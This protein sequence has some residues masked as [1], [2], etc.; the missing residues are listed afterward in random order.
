MVVP[1]LESVVRRLMGRLPADRYDSARDVLAALDVVEELLVTNA[2]AGASTTELGPIATSS[3]ETMIAMPVRS[4]RRW[5]VAGGVLASLGTV[6]FTVAVRHAGTAATVAT[7]SP[8][9]PPPIVAVVVRGTAKDAP[10]PIADAPS[11]AIPPPPRTVARP[12]MQRAQPAVEPLAPAVSL[13]DAGVPEVALVV[14]TVP[15]LPAKIEPPPPSPAPIPRPL[16]TRART[17]LRSLEVRGSL[18]NAVIRR[19]LERLEPQ[20]RRCFA[21]QAAASRRSTVTTVRVTFVVDDTRQASSVQAG[22]S[23]WPG[24]ATCVGDVVRELRT[25][26]APDVGSV[27]V[28][29]D[30]QFTPEEST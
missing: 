17:E 18:S 9:A 23:T 27:P 2:T 14:P 21:T 10:P 5:W 20:M 26:T 13:L 15:A 8:P 6:G 11:V 19:A 16:T 28:S 29:V 24:L 22:S 1:A 7:L 4:R 30:V 25:N 3:A 12:R